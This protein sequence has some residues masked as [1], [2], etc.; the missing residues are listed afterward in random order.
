MPDSSIAQGDF[1]LSPINSL[2]YQIL[3][4]IRNATS[5]NRQNKVHFLKNDDFLP[6]LMS[7]LSQHNQHPKVKAQT[8]AVLW[9]LVHNHQGIK[10]AINRS[11]VISELQLMK[12]EYQREVDREGFMAHAGGSGVDALDYHANYTLADSSKKL[13]QNKMMVKDMNQFMLKS[14][15]GILVLVQA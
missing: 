5:D 6:C 3:L 12:S 11:S 9:T 8:A 7:F 15:T 4:F 10:A 14:L 2:I 13:E 1:H